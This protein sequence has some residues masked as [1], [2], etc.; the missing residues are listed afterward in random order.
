MQCKQNVQERTQQSKP[1]W[2]R[3]CKCKFSIW[4]MQWGFGCQHE[5]REIREL[6]DLQKRFITAPQQSSCDCF[7]KISKSMLT[8]LTTQYNATKDFNVIY[9]STGII[10]AMLQA[11]WGGFGIECFHCRPQSKLFHQLKKRTGI[12]LILTSYQDGK[13]NIFLNNHSN[14]KN[15]IYLHSS[16]PF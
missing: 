3:Y 6:S 15:E 14:H 4:F 9:S 2:C 13:Q 5:K 12:N 10:N 16:W 7:C 11:L 1:C 8:K